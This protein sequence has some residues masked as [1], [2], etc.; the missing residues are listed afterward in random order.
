MLACS[1]DIYVQLRLWQFE[2]LVSYAIWFNAF[3]RKL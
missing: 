2:S 3:S 1:F